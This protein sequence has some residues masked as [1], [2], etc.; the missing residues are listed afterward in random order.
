MVEQEIEGGLT[1]PSEELRQIIDAGRKKAKKLG[2]KQLNQEVILLGFLSKKT[3]QKIL[4]EH[5]DIKARKLEEKLSSVIRNSDNGKR[6]IQQVD[7][8]ILMVILEAQEEAAKAG[9]QDVGPFQLFEG[10]VLKGTGIVHNLLEKASIT[11]DKLPDIRELAR[12]M[13][14][15][16]QR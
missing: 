14:Q 4:Q 12:N 6:N 11:K 2:L 10:L 3:F 8:A 1:Q 13:Q 5:F 9:L 16:L 7:P 15:T